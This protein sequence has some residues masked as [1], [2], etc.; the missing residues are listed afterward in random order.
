MRQVHWRAMAQAVSRQLLTAEAWVES[1]ASACGICGVSKWHWDRFISEYFGFPLSSSFYQCS[2][3]VYHR[4]YIISAIAIIVTLRT[5]TRMMDI[6]HW[7]YSAVTSVRL[8]HKNRIHLTLQQTDRLKQKWKQISKRREFLYSRRST[9]V[10]LLCS[11]Q[12]SVDTNGTT[13]WQ[14]RAEW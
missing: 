13:R 3:S 5:I 4:R 6:A 8:Q 1:Q 10:L 9:F 12:L 11:Q 14:Q 7:I 2:I